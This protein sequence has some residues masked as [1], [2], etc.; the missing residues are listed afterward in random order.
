M[1]EDALDLL[2]LEEPRSHVPLLEHRDVRYVYQLAVPPFP[3]EDSF[4]RRQLAID[5]AVEYVRSSRSWL[6]S[7]LVGPHRRSLAL[8]GFAPRAG[9]GRSSTTITSFARLKMNAFTS[10]VVIEA[11]R[12][13]PSYGSKCSRI[14]RPSGI[15]SLL[16]LPLDARSHADIHGPYIALASGCGCYDRSRDRPRLVLLGSAVAGLPATTNQ[17]SSRPRSGRTSA[18]QTS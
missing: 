8:G 10:A 18:R 1:T 13:P 7:V 5:L 14:R 6:L 12:L 4:Q 17:R 9:R 2:A 16:D 3:V 11:K 15:R